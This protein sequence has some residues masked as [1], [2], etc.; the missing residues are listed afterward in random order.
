[1]FVDLLLRLQHFLVLEGREQHCHL[2]HAHEVI[3]DAAGHLVEAELDGLGPADV[4]PRVEHAQLLVLLA[5]V[6]Q[7]VLVHD[8]DHQCLPARESVQQ[9]V[10]RGQFETQ[11]VEDDERLCVLVG[12]TDLVVLEFIGA[13]GVELTH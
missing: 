7:V 9:C 12:V 4:E 1:M 6:G 5:T 11:V 13:Q 2:L 10:D 8:R 3:Q